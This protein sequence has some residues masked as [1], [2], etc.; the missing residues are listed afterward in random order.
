LALGLGYAFVY[1]PN[2]ELVSPTVFLAGVLFGIRTG[3]LVGILTYFI[4][5]ILNPLGMSPLPL[6]LTQ[7]L[8][9]SLIGLS[10]GF[11]HKKRWNKAHIILPLGILITLLSDT[12]TTSAGF[13][14]FPSRKS[15][16]AYFIFGLPFVIWHIF[17]QSIIY[18]F[19]LPPTIQKIKKRRFYAINLNKHDVL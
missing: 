15:F 18:G 10:G 5:G 19:V 8:V 3:T 2:F 9:G 7:I 4:F 17:T 14:F 11:C 1:I 16:L 6:L 12:L 13:V